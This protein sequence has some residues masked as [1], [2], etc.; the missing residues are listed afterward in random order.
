MITLATRT[1]AT[2]IFF[3]MVWDVGALHAADWTVPVEVRYDTKRCVSYRARLSGSFLVIQATLESGWHTYAMDNKQRAQEKLAGKKPLGLDRPTEIVLLEGL[4][5]ERPW[6]QSP[7]KDF[8]K[9]DL[10]WFSWGFEEQALFI[11]KVRPLGTE[12][13]RLAVR[14]QACT[15][16]TCKNIDV[17][18]SIPLGGT[19]PNP[20]VSDI[21]LKNLIQVRE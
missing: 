15:A 21:N 6:Y 9:R 18:L 1:V 13:A 20:D 19:H 14:G 3:G 5:L 16:T 8:S 2:I 17:E 4:E 7:P 12:T 11:A 10:R